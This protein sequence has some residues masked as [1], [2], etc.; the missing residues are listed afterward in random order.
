MDPATR[1][2][3]RIWLVALL[4]GVAVHLALRIFTTRDFAFALA[5]FVYAGVAWPGFRI[6]ARRNGHALSPVVYFAS[7]GI[8]SVVLMFV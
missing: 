1:K 2:I 7:F 4:A 5:F 6:L 3:L 8:A